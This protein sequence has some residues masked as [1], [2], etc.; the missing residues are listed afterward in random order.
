MTHGL[1]QMLLGLFLLTSICSARQ[2]REEGLDKNSLT[3]S[4]KVLIV[5]LSRTN[6]TKKIAEIIH[7]NIGGMLVGLELKKPYPRDREKFCKPI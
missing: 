3:R 2:S 7:E 1:K 5:Y 6:N 4:G